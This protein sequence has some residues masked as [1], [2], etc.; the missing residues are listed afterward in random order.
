MRV[1]SAAR[2]CWLGLA[3]Y[4]QVYSL[5]QQLVE[6]C[7]QHEAS[8]VFLAV[9]HPAVFTL[10][11]RGG[12]QYLSVS[13]QF[14]NS[15]GIEIIATERGGVITFHGPGQL[16]LYPVLHLRRCGLSVT[17][18]VYLL[19][20]LMIRLASSFGVDA[21]RHPRNRGVWVD[22][23]KLGSL[24]VAIRHGVSFHGM[25]LNVDLCLDP[26]TWISPC[27]LTGVQMTSL[28]LE[29]KHPVSV[30][31]VLALFPAVL[32][33]IFPFSFTAVQQQ[34]LFEGTK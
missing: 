2:F 30:A 34:A 16:V 7:A 4:Q 21:T 6:H 14:I 25:A 22:G 17:D 5:Q 18:L 19:E 20:E 29:S 28:T 33:D 1:R 12:R 10:G 26:F 32:A 24:G 3:S 8:A 27:G 15:Q 23:K 11:K 13:E 9:E 31:E